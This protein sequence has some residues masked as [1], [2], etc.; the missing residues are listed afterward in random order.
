MEAFKESMRIKV[1]AI[2]GNGRSYAK[3]C[4]VE[5]CSVLPFRQQA[6]PVERTELGVAQ[7]D[8]R[9]VRRAAAGAGGHLNADHSVFAA[10][11]LGSLHAQFME[12]LQI[13]LVDRRYG[14]SFFGGLDECPERVEKFRLL[15]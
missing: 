15:I 10:I 5:R 9:Q 14:G 6:L 8:G 2:H 4:I 7:P 3:N 1:G 13:V 12:S 11:A